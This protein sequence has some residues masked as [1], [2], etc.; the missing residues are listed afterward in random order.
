LFD[1]INK[2]NKNVSTSLCNDYIEKIQLSHKR[3][4]TKMD[5]YFK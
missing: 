1:Q 4:H 5:D 2:T 3:L